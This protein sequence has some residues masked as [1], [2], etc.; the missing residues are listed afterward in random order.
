[1]PDLIEL[2]PLYIQLQ[3][4]WL[5]DN[6]FKP[7]SFLSHGLCIKFIKCCL[8]VLQN[9]A[10]FRSQLNDHLVSLPLLQWINTHIHLFTS[11]VQY[12]PS[13]LFAFFTY[14]YDSYLLMSSPLNCKLHENKRWQ[15]FEGCTSLAPSIMPGLE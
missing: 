10:L 4:H 11:I 1:M 5:S 15:I 2:S 7:C 12:T 14:I 6:L 3:T 8:F 9:H 13:Y